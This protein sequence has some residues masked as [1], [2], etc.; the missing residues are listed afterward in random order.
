MAYTI[1]K[2]TMD[3]FSEYNS[4][5]EQ[6]LNWPF[7]FSLPVW[8]QSW[9]ESFG[10]GYELSLRSVF[11]DQQL[12]GL[13]PLMRMNESA[14]LVGSPDVCDY[15]DFITAP[16]KEQEFFQA[17]LPDLQ[18]EG[19]KRLQ[20]NSQRPGAAVFKGLFAAENNRE[21]YLK[22][23]F[24]RENESFELNLPD[25]WEDYLAALSKKQ[26]HEVRR[27]LRRLERETAGYSYRIIK[28]CGPVQEF[29]PAFFNLVRFNPEKA[30]FFTPKMEQF[31]S[32]LVD[33]LACTGLARFGLLDLN[34]ITVAAVLYFDYRGRIHLYNSGY[35]ADYS[36]LSAGLLSKVLCIKQSIEH[37]RPVFDF[38]KGQEVYKTRLGGSPVPIYRV[39][40]ELG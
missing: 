25:H 21:C 10:E 34:G 8:L 1:K 13:A 24:S 27:K 20:L 33:N 28:D 39:E 4:E 12:I 31:F 19:I 26:R 17:L 38:L 3:T 9:W 23:S 15:L 11:K 16:G 22:L 35:N 18:K 2:E 29:I 36:S 14:A 30:D 40:I 7:V 6:F 32:R 5:T 37:K